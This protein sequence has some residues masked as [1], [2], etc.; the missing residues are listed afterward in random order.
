M[1]ELTVLIEGPIGVEGVVVRWVEEG[2]VISAAARGR[3]EERW[4]SYLADA[5]A[6]GKTLFNGAI[7]RLIEARRE[8]GGVELTLGP[9]DYKTFVVTAMR[10]R[11]WF[12]E[13]APEAI[14]GAMG[15]S[16]LLTRGEGAA[17]DSIARD[18]CVCG[19]GACAGRG[20]GI[21]GDGEVSG[22]RGGGVGASAD[23]VG[24][25]GGGA[26]G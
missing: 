20:A 3:I 4:G 6:Q 16:V 24:G 26:G 10:D 8:G 1:S 25:G 14:V 5:R 19:A 18:E 7:S 15:N 11:A 23:G 12:A 21:A 2:P 9:A 22:E 13:H 17:G